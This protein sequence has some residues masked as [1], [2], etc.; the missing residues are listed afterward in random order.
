MTEF[1]MKYIGWNIGATRV[2]RNERASH[3]E[4]LELKID[5]VDILKQLEDIKKHLLEFPSLAR[6]ILD[7]DEWMRGAE[8]WKSDHWKILES[9]LFKEKTV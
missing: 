3:I 2:E 1:E 7:K 6:E 8:D 4:I 9:S 5:G